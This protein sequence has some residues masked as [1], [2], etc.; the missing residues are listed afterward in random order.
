MLEELRTQGPSTLQDYLQILWRRKWLILQAAVIVPIA[1]ALWARQGET[2]YN[3]SAGVLMQTANLPANVLAVQDPTQLN[4][5]RVLQTQIPVAR[6]PVVARRTIQAAGLKGWSASDLLGESSVTSSPDSSDI[7]TFSVTDARAGRAVRLVNEYARQFTRYRREL[8]TAAIASAR[9]AVKIRI[10]ALA[11]AGQQRS[12]LYAN[13]VTT[14]QRLSTLAALQTSRAIV[15]RPATGAGKQGPAVKR[16]AVFGLALGLLLGFGLA[17]IRENLD[18]RVRA[19]DVVSRQLG[20]RLLGRVVEPPR[21]MRRRKRLVTLAE[22]FGAQSET[23]RMLAPNI[24]FA[25][26]KLGARLIMVTSALEREGKSTTAAN[27]AVSFARGGART[28]LLDLDPYGSPL[29]AFFEP[30]PRSTPLS[31]AGLTD[32]ILGNAPLEA[33]LNKIDVGPG[34][35]PVQDSS[36]NG[37]RSALS[38]GRLEIIRWGDGPPEIAGTSRLAAV[39][40]QL[41]VR[42]DV[43]LVDAPP[44]LRTAD[45]LTVSPHMDA[46]L[47]VVRLNLIR[48]GTLDDLRRVLDSC[49]APKLGFIATGA[50]ADAGYTYSGY[51]Y[52]G[53]E[54]PERWQSTIT[55]SAPSGEGKGFG[56]EEL[57]EPDARS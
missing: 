50:D 17:F 24:E 37:N 44:L 34:R 48:R 7:L 10:E 11:A 3:A 1:A 33:A 20:L 28:I 27:L 40:E 13:L 49:P 52:F 29:D 57:D 22:P 54:V 47:V 9:D 25:N 6:L 46:L 31:R 14:E 43:V 39:F 45:A 19:A 35:W 56:H 30:S 53:R 12:A 15:V 51:S 26:V 32:V 18:T 2:V 16:D 5:T 8:D 42:A 55:S 41:S 38:S 23:F 4:P 36:T 21:R